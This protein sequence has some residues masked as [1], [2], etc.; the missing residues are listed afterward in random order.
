MTGRGFMRDSARVLGRATVAAIAAAVAVF[1]AA[2]ALAGEGSRY[3][4]TDGMETLVVLPA[5]LV[6]RSAASLEGG[7]SDSAAQQAEEYAELARRS[8]DAR[9][10]GRAQA[11]V[12]PWID[13]PDPSPR[14]L[15][16][17]ADL[18]QQRHE[19]TRSR[20]LLDRSLAA[21]PRNA[22][23]RLMRAN[24]GL[25]AGDFAA[26]RADCLAV[27]QSDTVPGSICLASALTGP[28][29][30]DRAR[31]LLASLDRPEHGSVAIPHWRLMTQAD[32]ALRAGDDV[33]A[34]QYFER[35]LAL[36]PAHEET[37]VQLAKT[38][39]AR[40]DAARALALVK[41][42]DMS[43]ALLVARIRAA[44]RIDETAAA[45]A[46]REFEDLLAIGQRRGAENHLR[47]EG[48]IALHVAGDAIHALDLARRNF[49]VQKDTPDLRLFVDAA[50][51]AQDPQA[52][53]FARSW[54]D[55][56]GFED[57]VVLERLREAGM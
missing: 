56:T 49:A 55:S 17:A 44:S 36:D 27:M 10:F 28:G 4:P 38:L 50:I 11:L 9:Y 42:A 13:K 8:G 21:E 16:V 35:A 3:R 12:A 53:A 24:L 7:N 31:G 2:D 41:G 30:L 14:L 43:A 5:A 33:A 29:S 19:F 57:R 1:F 15:V 32:L 25:I 45:A 47:E 54:L 20:H 18:A 52:L 22:G 51:A 26:A 6:S 46:R 40:G 34:V 39:I 37:R 48:E 23:A